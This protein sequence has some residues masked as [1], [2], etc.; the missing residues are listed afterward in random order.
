MK[1]LA[2]FAALALAPAPVA[3]PVSHECPED[4]SLLLR[5]ECP[6]DGFPVLRHECPDDESMLLRPECP[7]D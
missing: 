7:E 5:H 2:L 3:G 4:E 1:A 6:E